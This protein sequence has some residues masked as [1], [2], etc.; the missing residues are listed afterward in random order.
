ME[1]TV[2]AI[3]SR[4]QKVNSG[5]CRSIIFTDLST[6]LR[7]LYYFLTVLPY[8]SCS[9]KTTVVLVVPLRFVFFFFFFSTADT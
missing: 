9:V 2:S 6:T 5:S 3:P 4:V 8:S 7:I 1:S